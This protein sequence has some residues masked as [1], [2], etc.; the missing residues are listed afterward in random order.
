VAGG[1]IEIEV[2]L[3]L[4]SNLIAF[5]VH[6]LSVSSITASCPCSRISRKSP[7]QNRYRTLIIRVEQMILDLAGRQDWYGE[8]LAWWGGAPERPRRFT[9][10][11]R[12]TP[13]I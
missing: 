3:L 5:E 9:G 4:L 2:D 7:N 12:F 1:K 11:N 13:I 6:P 8:A 10:E